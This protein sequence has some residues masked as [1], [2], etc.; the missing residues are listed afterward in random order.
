MGSIARLFCGCVLLI[1]AGLKAFELAADSTPIGPSSGQ[2][3]KLLLVQFEV[4]LVAWLIYGRAARELRRVTIGVFAAF[5]CFSLYDVFVRAP[6][7]NCFGTLQVNPGITFAI[8]VA[9]VIMLLAWQPQP[10]GVLPQFKK[11][12]GVSIV[13]GIIPF[14][15][16][17]S[18]PIWQRADLEDAVIVPARVDLGHLAHDIQIKASV[19]LYNP[20]D[21]PIEIVGAESYCSCA[22]PIGLR[23]SLQ[24]RKHTVL[25]VNIKPT[26]S[27][28]FQQR[29]YYFLNHARQQRV[30][31]DF[32]GFVEEKIDD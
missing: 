20:T 16:L 26:V 2:W 17:L 25:N 13:A 5:A 7:C 12:S 15:I 24:P 6:S 4:F 9:S 23:F 21:G 30:A 14:G 10:A 28:C 1:A 32:F 3:L 29:I 22:T 18:L 27:G 31:V 8:D 11:F 19:Q